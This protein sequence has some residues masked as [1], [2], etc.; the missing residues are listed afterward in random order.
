[1]YEWLKIGNVSGVCDTEMAYYRGL[2][3]NIRCIETLMKLLIQFTEI[4][5]N[6]NIRCIETSI[7]FTFFR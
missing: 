5:L 4:I 2:N 6:S 7:R 3:S 1:M